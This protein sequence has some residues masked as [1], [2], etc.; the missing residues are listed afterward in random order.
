[1]IIK[2]NQSIKD[3]FKDL[4]REKR[5]FKYTLVAE[6]TL[7]RCNNGSNRYDIETI[8]IR[9]NA[10][11]VINQRFNLEASYE[12]I[13]N[14]LDIWTGFGSAWIIDKIG[15]IYINIANYDPLAGSSYFSLPPGLRNSMK[16]L[17][18][19]K[20]KDIKCFKWC[21]VRLLNPQNKDPDRIKK[22]D[23]KIEATLDYRGIDFP[24]KVKD[25]EIIECKCFYI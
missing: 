8:F 18:N 20:N 21:H 9:S 15:N 22:Q 2:K 11:T 6:I 23:K 13:K 1:M 3:L 14:I 7:K 4:L 24:I 16:G 5:G 12:I 17:I 19:L 10:I 25:Y